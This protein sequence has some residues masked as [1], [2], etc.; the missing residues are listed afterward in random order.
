M[1]LGLSLSLFFNLFFKLG[2]FFIY[3]SNAIPKVPQ[4]LPLTPLPT[5]SHFL[6]LAFPRTE[7]IKFARPRGL[8]CQ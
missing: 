4:T 6:A 3:I 5:Y 8:S 1:L 7:D 2:I